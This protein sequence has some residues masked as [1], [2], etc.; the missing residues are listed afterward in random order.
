VRGRPRLVFGR[1]RDGTCAN[2]VDGGD[3]ATGS[4][5][6]SDPC[7]RENGAVR[8]LVEDGDDSSMDS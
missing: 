1:T 5:R 4:G 8:L 6:F 3:V 2:G 7:C